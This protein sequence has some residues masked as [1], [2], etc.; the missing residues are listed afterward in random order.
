MKNLSNENRQGQLPPGQA[1]SVP[2]ANGGQAGWNGTRNQDTRIYEGIRRPGGVAFEE[3][4]PEDG[5]E[6]DYEDYDQVTRADIGQD[7]RNIMLMNEE[8]DALAEKIKPVDF[9]ELP[10]VE[11]ASALPQEGGPAAQVQGAAPYP[12]DPTYGGYIQNNAANAGGVYGQTER[13]YAGASYGATYAAD[14]YLDSDPGDVAYPEE[15]YGNPDYLDPSYG[16][17]GGGDVPPSDDPDGYE[18]RNNGGG[19]AKRLRRRTSRP[20]L[21]VSYAFVAIFLLLIGH[22]VYFNIKERDAILASPYN[23]RQDDLAANVR[24]GSILASDGSELAVTHTDELGNESRVYPYGSIF[25]HVVGYST[26][27]RS[28]LEASENVALLTSHMDI[29]ERAERELRGEKSLGDHVITTLNA[30]LQQTAWYALGDR[31][32]AVVALNPK[33]GAILA[34]VSKPDFDPNTIVE[35]WQAIVNDPGNSCL[36]NRATQGLY[37]PGSTYKILT[38]LAYFREHGT[39]DGY[40]FDCT[41][42]ITEGENAIHCA[43]GS[44]HGSL[45]FG[46]AFAWSCNCA[47][48]DM[49]RSMGAKSLINVMDSLLLGKKL[50]CPLPAS[51]SRYTLSTTDDTFR[52]MQTAFGQGGTVVTPWQMALIVAA[53]ANKGE[54]MEPYLVEKVVNVDGKAVES[55]K[56]KNYKRLLS[57]NEAGNLSNL[58]RAVVTNGSA[59]EL[60]SLPVAC[61]GKTG[62]AE[63]TRSDGSR[64]THAWFVGYAGAKDPDIVIAVIAEDAG[65][66]SEVAVPIAHAVLGAYYS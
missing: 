60:M 13:G 29:L 63:F 16:G 53:I 15:G 6:E 31:R 47:F 46:G 35:S 61:Y 43:G 44:V 2:N 23:R 25:A 17:D 58:L 65:S 18:D 42:V 20:Y 14:G 5:P 39:F 51:K 33:T 11:V 41:G 62:S 26:N 40:H 50:P 48:S 38:S 64:G 1:G 8:R 27:G 59:Q 9:E 55:H 28:G 19:R 36:L 22:L 54:L 3:N 30:R 57:E 32:G 4:Y 56:A 49:G 66:G 45:D 37:V 21:F 10:P 24:R 34:M 7:V 52:V 12:L